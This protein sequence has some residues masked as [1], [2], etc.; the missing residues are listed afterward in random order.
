MSGRSS[1]P[2]RDPAAPK[3]N[4][5][6]YLLYQ[7]AMRDTFKQQVRSSATDVPLNL[8]SHGRLSRLPPVTCHFPL[9]SRHDVWPALE[10]HLGHVRRNAP[11]GEGCK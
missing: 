8:L 1:R 5:S 3:R 9:E 2:P 6:A 4:M 10:V 11:R 7:N